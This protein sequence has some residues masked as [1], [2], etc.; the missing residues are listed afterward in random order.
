MKREKET[1]KNV[2]V[3][4]KDK[5]VGKTLAWEL[6]VSQHTR[7]SFYSCFSKVHKY[8]SNVFSPSGIT[9]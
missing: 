4:L 7:N 9:L 5:C 6:I 3:Q 1:E 8:T 2:F